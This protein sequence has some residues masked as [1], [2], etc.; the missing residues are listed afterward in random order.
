MPQMGTTFKQ[1][2]LTRFWP[3][4]VIGALSLG[5]L[6][7]QH[8]QPPS[9][10]TLNS[11]QAALSRQ[12]IDQWGTLASVHNKQAIAR[13]EQAAPHNSYAAA[14]LGRWFIQ[15]DDT[16]AVQAGL[17]RLKQ[18]AAA[19]EPLAEFTLGK[20]WFKG[21]A[22]LAPNKDHAVALLQAALQHGQMGAAYYLGVITKQ[23]YTGHAP[24]ALAAADYFNQAAK[25]GIADAQFMLGEMYL[26]GDGVAINPK[27][28]RHWL[29][30][31]AEQDQPEA[32][33]A[34]LMAK[35]RGE[36][37][38]DAHDKEGIAYQSMEARHSLRLRP[39]PP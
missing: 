20:L 36:L 18:A 8:N 9:T 25:A 33:L 14:V 31:A 29:E 10:D 30:E 23:G 4:W 37:G 13:L 32:S 39:P 27:L 22:G 2:K 6:W 24:N 15:Q 17:D 34:L 5:A 19:Q 38:Y 21:A 1:S 35:S 3:V 11:S 28:A 7:T 12:Q 16:Q 26:N